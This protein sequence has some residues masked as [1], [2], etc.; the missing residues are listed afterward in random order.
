MNKKFALLTFSLRATER[1][2]TSSGS[3]L[4]AV[5]SFDKGAGKFLSG[6]EFTSMGDDLLA[7]REEVLGVAKLT[8]IMRSNIS[9]LFDEAR[10]LMSDSSFKNVKLSLE[11][12]NGDFEIDHVLICKSSKAKAG[13]VEGDDV[14]FVVFLQMLSEEPQNSGAIEL[15]QRFATASELWKFLSAVGALS[16]RIPEFAKSTPP[17]FYLLQGDR[18]LESA[19]N[20]AQ[21]ESLL[22]DEN[23]KNAR[24][25]TSLICAYLFYSYLLCLRA[26]RLAISLDV[27]GDWDE[28]YRKLILA[29][30]KLAVGRKYALLKN[31]AMPDSFIL[32]VFAGVSR[33][34]R[35]D[36][37]L[38]NLS[39]LLDE[40][41]KTLETQNS[42]VASGRLRAIE[43]IIFAS[44][45]L[46]LGVALNSIQMLPFYDQST[47]NTLG[48]PEFWVVFGVIFCTAFVG[49]WLLV[50]GRKVRAKIGQFL[51]WK[52]W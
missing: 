27:N 19:R 39:V 35:L 33:I 48:R 34:Y 21:V 10:L 43:V 14:L 15:G 18:V 23:G 2:A 52:L 11:G 44:T 20:S 17:G 46:G 16:G 9:S 38:D 1:V 50:H 36:G 49:W 32:P 40:L 51:F 37:Q 30:K 6:A 29:R 25:V 42:Y 31:R 28:E 26:E 7:G 22:S 4:D 8:S 5:Q 12:C 13:Q 41:S 3:A 45:I 47:E 24:I